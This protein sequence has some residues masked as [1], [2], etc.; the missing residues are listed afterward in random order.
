VTVSVVICAA[1]A[2]WTVVIPTAIVA[3]RLRRAIAL[4][5][6]LAAP[7]ASESVASRPC[8]GRRRGASIGSVVTRFR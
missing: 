6:R 1:L 2:V 3:L 4:E 5:R 8:E 7:S